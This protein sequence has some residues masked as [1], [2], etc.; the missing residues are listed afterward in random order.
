MYLVTSLRRKKAFTLIELL[1]VI[2]I[3]AILIGL[4]LPAVQKVREAAARSKC[5]N[6]FK[7]FGLALQ[8]YHDTYFRLPPGGAYGV[9]P[10]VG[11]DAT[12][13][14][15]NWDSNQ[16]NWLIYTLPFMEQSAMYNLINPRANVLN[17]V[18]LTV[19]NTAI[20]PTKP[21]LPYARC[22]SD[23]YDPA[24]TTTNYV[25][26]SGPTCLASPNCPTVWNGWCQPE[27]SG[28][29]GGYNGMGYT[30][31][32]DTGNTTN[33][34]DVR[35]LFNRLGATINYASCTDGLSNTLEIGES[36]PR[37]ND[38]LAGNTWWHYNGGGA[39]HASTISPINTR[40]DGNNCS[41]PVRRQ[42]NDW[43]NS[44]G[45][46]S[47]HTGGANFVFADGS[48]KFLRSSIDHRTYQLLGCRND[49]QPTGS[50]F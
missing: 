12:T 37:H 11:Y 7:Q 17:S 14:N 48:V 31:S 9:C 19:E 41:D 36:L 22:P 50:D 38:H 5:Q 6:N 1:V 47:N 21:K 24:A 35:G 28:L 40:T 2:A 42:S 25:A 34:K 45:F 20:F 44:L 4:L 13:T 8:S 39:A 18:S 23:D 15:G 49:G 29:G 27:T 3:I 46:K 33:P 16:G 43:N 32:A 26:C 30:I 10:G